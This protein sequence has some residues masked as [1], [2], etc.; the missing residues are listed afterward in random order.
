[1]YYDTKWKYARV[2]ILRHLVCTRTFSTILERYTII[3]KHGH[4][5]DEI[6]YIAI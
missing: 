6:C 2:L 1:M 4:D 3:S 5:I